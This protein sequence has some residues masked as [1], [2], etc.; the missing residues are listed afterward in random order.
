[1]FGL[2]LDLNSG[3][4]KLGKRISRILFFF[5]FFKVGSRDLFFS[6]KLCDFDKMSFEMSFTGDKYFYCLVN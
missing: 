3:L 2:S 1:M 6:L 5:F 4:I